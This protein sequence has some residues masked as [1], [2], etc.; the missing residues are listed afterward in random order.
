MR[1]LFATAVALMLASGP[2]MA[3]HH[4]GGHRG[5]GS[6]WPGVGV[7][8]ALGALGAYGYYNYNPYQYTPY[9]GYPAAPYTP[10]RQPYCYYD[11]WGRY[12]CQ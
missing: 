4:G 8:A 6:F 1:Y 10:Y 11:S 12:T 5:G 7:G 9:Y 2:A 3:Q